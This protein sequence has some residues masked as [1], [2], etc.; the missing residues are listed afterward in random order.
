MKRILL[1]V[2]A[3]IIH[4]SA[5]GQFKLTANGMK[6]NENEDAEFI[7]IQCDG[8]GQR[9]LFNIVL[10]YANRTYNSPNFVVS[11]VDVKSD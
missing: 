2:F 4:V 6:A 11:N 7:V 3:V 8:K 1:L 10:A 9:E 5:F